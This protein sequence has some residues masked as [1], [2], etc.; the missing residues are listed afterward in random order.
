MAR[1][2]YFRDFN[3]L[4]LTNE[5]I[6]FDTQWTRKFL[7]G[8]AVYV[9]KRDNAT[10]ILN[11]KVRNTLSPILTQKYKKGSKVVVIDTT[12]HMPPQV[13]QLL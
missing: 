4:E 2:K 13:T 8:R 5:V 9:A 10:L 1:R 3:I 11:R 6:Q 12:V 7:R